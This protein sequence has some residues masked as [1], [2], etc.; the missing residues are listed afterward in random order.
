MQPRTILQE[1]LDQA[2]KENLIY[3]NPAHNTTQP[4][5]VKKEIQ[6]LSRARNIR[7]HMDLPVK[8]SP[9]WSNSQLI[10]A[11]ILL[12]SIINDIIVSDNY[13]KSRKIALIFWYQLIP[14]YLT[15]YSRGII[16]KR[17]E[18]YEQQKIEN[19]LEV[20]T[21]LDRL[22]YALA[23]G[24]AKINFQIDRR[25]DAGR[26]KRYTNRYT[27]AA[28]FPDEDPVT[29]LKRELEYLTEQD[30]VETV[31]DTRYPKQSDMR[32]FGKKYSEKNVYIK[33]RVEL[34]NAIGVGGDNFIFVMSFHFAE[35]DFEDSDFPY[36]KRGEYKC[37]L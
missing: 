18:A 32:V 2:V 21:Y 35:E 16:M 23:S 13:V 1:A 6:P 30:Y 36:R 17:K 25:V 4:R 9:T 8:K 33:I 20:T 28:L 26:S 14:K 10:C 12:I 37:K 34:F 29:V 5:Q 11:F 15:L 19:K 31:K 7:L 24:T 3:S 27:M 22:K